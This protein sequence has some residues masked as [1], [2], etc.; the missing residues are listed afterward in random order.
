MGELVGEQ[1][2]TREQV[3]AEHPSS[4]IDSEGEERCDGCDKWL[5]SGQHELEDHQLWMLDDAGLATEADWAA[6]GVY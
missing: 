3:L 1:T 5:E 4:F 6:R 2:P